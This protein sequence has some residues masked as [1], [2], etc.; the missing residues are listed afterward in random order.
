[1]CV[2]MGYGCVGSREDLGGMR[3]NMIKYTVLNSQR[4]NKTFL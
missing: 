3:K 2:N 1:M 4:I